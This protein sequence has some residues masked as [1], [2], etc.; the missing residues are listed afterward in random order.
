MFLVL[1]SAVWVWVAVGG[2]FLFLYFSFFMSFVLMV[3][4]FFI[5]PGNKGGIIV[6][7]MQINNE[8]LFGIYFIYVFM[9]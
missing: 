2:T 9:M 5:V 3:F 7:K 6:L 1:G 4:S 8:W